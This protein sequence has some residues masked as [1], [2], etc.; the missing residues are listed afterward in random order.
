[1]P[2]PANKPS[3]PDGLVAVVK[4]DC[5]TCALIE[6]VL[7]Q[8]KAA[9]RRLTVYTQDDPTFPSG[10]DVVD[11]R[12]LEVSWHHAV[13]TVPTLMR[14]ESGAEVERTIG[15]NRKDWEALSG[16]GD[17][18]TRLPAHRP[19][20]GSRSV[21]PDKADALGVRFSGSKLKSR[22]IELA[23]LEDEVESLFER[24]WTDGLPGV[25]PT[26]GRVLRMLEG[27][28]RSP[29][30]VV[31]G[32]PPPLISGTAAKMGINAGVAG[33][34]PPDLP[35]VLPPPSAASTPP[36]HIH[37]PAAPPTPRRS[38]P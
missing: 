6:P 3:L 30:E 37:P 10:V 26:E 23:S 27:T 1:M 35:P 31:A 17:L 15:W 12:E 5:P 8:I 29:D 9:G 33:C 19:G 28:A 36:V 13:E 18:G 32:A 2:A 20:C 24:G 7:R 14:V 38:P 34:K 21:A 11:D 22:R 16:V 4:R 25:P